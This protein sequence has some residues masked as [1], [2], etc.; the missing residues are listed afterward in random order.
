M[1]LLKMLFSR[2]FLPALRSDSVIKKTAHRR[3]ISI[4]LNLLLTALLGLNLTACGTDYYETTE[5]FGVHKRDILVDRAE[6]ARDSQ[7]AAK[8]QFSALLNFDGGD[9]QNTYARLNTKF[10][11]S[12]D[13]VKSV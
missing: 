3:Q 6:E 1:E 9:L 7:E 5:L 10:E 12:E 2:F 11:K 4:P 8:E 13:R